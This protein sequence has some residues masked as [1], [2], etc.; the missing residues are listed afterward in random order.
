MFLL[1]VNLVLL[2]LGMFLD[3]ASLIVL[4]APTLFQMAPQFGVDPI[5]HAVIMIAN[6]EIA[7]TP[8]YSLTALL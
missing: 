8:D 2:L 4:T 3:G 7:H 6:M 1:A 5:H